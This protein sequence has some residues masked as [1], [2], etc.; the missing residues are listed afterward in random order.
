MPSGG[1]WD[2][3]L[4]D[5]PSPTEFE[6]ILSQQDGAVLRLTLNRP[7]KLNAWTPQMMGE[8]TTAILAAN[9]DDS[10]GA[11]VVTGAGRG[12]CAGADVGAVFQRDAERREAR[13]EA[14]VEAPAE[15]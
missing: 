10:V 15:R 13:A 2:V 11:I 3:I 7:E 9:D 5:V 6:Q 4:A 8:L 12:F 1:R 14:P